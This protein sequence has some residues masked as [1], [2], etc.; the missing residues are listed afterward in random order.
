MN[1]ALLACS[2][3][4]PKLA[5][6]VNLSGVISTRQGMINREQEVKHCFGLSCQ[7]CVAAYSSEL[8]GLKKLFWPSITLFC[9]HTD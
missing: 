9:K 5:Q 8:A 6:I 2:S 7:H 4:G 3:T 1:Y